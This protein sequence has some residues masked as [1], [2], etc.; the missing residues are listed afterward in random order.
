MLNSLFL[1]GGS[2]F[3]GRHIQN[4]F[5]QQYE[6]YAPSRQE[7]ELT[8]S[9]AVAAYL[10]N[11]SAIDYVINSAN[12][13]GTRNSNKK[14]QDCLLE[15]LRVFRNIF[16]NSKGMKRFI[17]L[18]SG[19]EYTK[20]LAIP[21]AREEHA[22]KI[23]PQ[24]AYGLAKF[25]MGQWLEQQE[26]GKYV[27]LRIFGNFG[28]YED[29][30]TRFI[31]NAIVRALNNLPIVVNQNSLFD[32]IYVK[33]FTEILNYFVR[34]PAPYISYNVTTGKPM[35]LIELATIV[36]EVTG[37]KHAIVVKNENIKEQYTGCNKRLM[38]FLPDSFQF[39]SINAAIEEL[40]NWYEHQIKSFTQDDIECLQAMR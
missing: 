36:K 25:F 2:G 27:N 28:P 19:A 13:G 9:E 10:T 33:D 30:T 7:L 1:S 26:V 14:E 38:E 20:P 21:N 29:Y 3:L 24:D 11:I 40:A 31:S 12:V 17:N 39:T 4:K 15:N 8:D 18:G 34:N 6:I 5:S 37:T 35:S 23:I 16:Q 22:G 32:Y